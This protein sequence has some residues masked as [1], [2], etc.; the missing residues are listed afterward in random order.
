M[1]KNSLLGLLI[2]ISF[3]FL[4][5]CSKSETDQRDKFLGNWEGTMNIKFPALNVD[6]TDIVSQSVSKSTSN[7]TQIL[8]DGSVA[9][10]NGNSYTYD[11]R[12]ESFSDPTV[13]TVVAQLQGVGIING[14][15]ITESGTI[16]MVV[17]G[18][19]YNGS[20]TATLT[21]K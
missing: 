5:S 19:T 18:V 16:K 9:T 20:W 8:I 13:G 1:K 2:L 10:V 3:T 7:S 11:S 14:S 6:E 15:S 4:G 21:K 12:S 17:L